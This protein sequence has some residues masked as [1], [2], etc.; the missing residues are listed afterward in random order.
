MFTATQS[1]QTIQPIETG[2]MT[3]FAYLNRGMYSMRL[4]L[5][6]SCGAL[7]AET[8]STVGCLWANNSVALSI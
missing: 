8:L 1:G 6:D 3:R 4:R 2:F 7:S 5:G